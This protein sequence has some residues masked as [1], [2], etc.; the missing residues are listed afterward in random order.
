MNVN[1]YRIG[2][3]PDI[4]DLEFTIPIEQVWDLTG[5]DEGYETYEREIV[6]S[7]LNQ[8]DFETNRIAH[9]P[10]P[11]V[12]LPQDG[13]AINYNFYFKSANTN[14]YVC[15]YLPKFD[16][17]QIYYFTN[18]FVSSFWKLDLYDTP[19]TQSQKN[20]ITIILPVSQGFFEQSQ[21]GVNT[22]NIRKPDFRLDFVG[23]KEGFFI[24]WLKKKN[25][26]DIKTFYMSAK[27]FDAKNGQFIKFM[28]R[29]Q[30]STLGSVFGFRPEDYFYYKV[31]L[32]YPTRTYQV[33][34]Y[35]NNR[36]GTTNSIKWYQYVN[37]SL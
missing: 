3:T 16:T 25:F 10:Y 23:E 22:V 14:T 32:D 7:L 18:Q 6:E 29:P 11:S 20:Y 5:V 24:Y 30:S 15:S 9:K 33:F 17:K 1:K 8:E 21:L 27:F 26:L 19:N 34:D 4:T 31:D 35:N 13:T 37:P 36:I 28:N 2:I 12:G